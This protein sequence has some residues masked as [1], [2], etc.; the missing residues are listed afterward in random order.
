VKTKFRTHTNYC[1]GSRLTCHVL[2]G[3][4]T[5][6]KVYH[7]A[8]VRRTERRQCACSWV[9]KLNALQQCRRSCRHARGT[10][11]TTGTCRDCQMVRRTWRHA[12]AFVAR[13]AFFLYSTLGKCGK[14][15]LHIAHVF[16]LSVGITF[17]KI[18]FWSFRPIF[19][20][21]MELLL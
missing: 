20:L 14:H 18:S 3:V 15:R 17:L 4:V 10:H 2:R 1:H 13:C 7:L 12:N 16:W 5:G 8:N 9:L 21:W 19:L 6:V 11:S